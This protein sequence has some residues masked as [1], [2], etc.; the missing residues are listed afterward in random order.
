MLE[1]LGLKYELVEDA[2]PLSRRAKAYN[3]TGKVPVLLEF[4]HCR[5]GGDGDDA[6][7]SFVL[8]ESVAINTYLGDKYG[9]QAVADGT[10]EHPLVPSLL[11]APTSTTAAGAA[12]TPARDASAESMKER[13]TYDQ[14]VSFL[15]SELDVQGMWMYRKHVEMGQYF[16]AVPELAKICRRH[17]RK[18]S[19]A[20]AAQC[21]PYLLGEKF[22]AADILYVHLLDWCQSVGWHLDEE[23]EENDNDNGHADTV[24]WPSNLDAY[25]QLCRQR[26]AYQ[27]YLALQRQ[28]LARQKE[29][30]RQLAQRQR[31]RQEEGNAETSQRVA[32]K[33]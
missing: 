25:L 6:T 11:A 9:P 21:R 14:T 7:P 26:P 18:Y 19:A 17:F 16:G 33:L 31:E 32:S 20:A 12:T 23:G 27:R 29:K 24:P 10:I 15:Q 8:A 22:T 5:S 4:G 3:A 13:A 1:E 28:S 30:K 2:R